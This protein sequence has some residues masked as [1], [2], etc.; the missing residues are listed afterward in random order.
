MCTMWSCDY[1]ADFSIRFTHASFCIWNNDTHKP[2]PLIMTVT[3]HNAWC[4]LSSQRLCCFQKTKTHL[5]PFRSQSSLQ[6]RRRS[7]RSPPCQI[8][9]LL[10]VC[11][12]F[13]PTSLW[14]VSDVGDL[15]QGR[16]QCGLKNVAG[17]AHLSASLLSNENTDRVIHESLRVHFIWGIQNWLGSTA[18]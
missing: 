7:N 2:R 18:A 5:L 6:E 1:A 15:R 11:A 9:C 14:P 4:E 3:L 16:G 17:S 8:G 12:V 13:T 10:P